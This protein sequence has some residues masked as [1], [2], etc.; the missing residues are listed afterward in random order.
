MKINVTKEAILHAIDL[1]DSDPKLL[2]GRYSS[3]YDLFYKGKTYPPILVLSEANKIVGGG[4]LK[5]SDFKNVQEAFKVLNEFGFD[6][7]SKEGMSL[8]DRLLRFSEVYDEDRKEKFSKSLESFQIICKE[9]PAIMK[10]KLQKSDLPIQ[11]SIGQGNFANYPWVAIF[12]PQVSTGATNGYYVVLLISD[13][14]ERIYLT[15]NQGS[16]LQSKENQLII[17]NH[18]FDVL[19]EVPGFMKGKLPENGLVR[20]YKNDP[21]NKT[22]KKYESTNLFYREYSIKNFNESDFYEHLELLLEAYDECVHR[23]QKKGIMNDEGIEFSTDLLTRDF[24]AAKLNY[25]RK[26][27]Q[28]FVASLLTKPFLLLSGLSGS[29]KTKIAQG[30][31]HW[32]CS[33]TNQYK[34]V[35]VGADWTNREP[36]LG[37]PNGLDPEMYTTPD[38]GVLQ[39]IIEAS[40][41]SHLPYFLIL[42][43]M[44]LSHV[45]RYFADFLS[46]MESNDTI[47]LYTGKERKSADDLFIP[48]ELGWPSNLFI[49]GTVNIDETT[50]MFSPKVLDRANVIEFRLSSKDLNAYLASPSKPN[51]EM[52]VGKGSLM[53]ASFLEMAR[54]ADFLIVEE[55]SNVLSAFF[56]ELSGVGAEFGYRTANEIVTL[57]TKLNKLDPDL[58]S[59]EKIDI[60]VMQKLLPKLHGSRAKIVKVLESML[61]L[62]LVNGKLFRIEDLNARSFED[63]EIRYPISFEKL[64]RM[65]TNVIANGF[66]SYAEA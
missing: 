2:R 8:R 4:E 14:L 58:S 29:G 37:Y 23:S 44:N 51:L 15:L 32:I 3:T 9:I 59:D 64:S 39:L 33:E 40:K 10:R 17:T 62:C 7:R 22:G 5:H 55:I 30:F 21:G 61:K 34:V 12:N 27:T 46:V 19:K 36:L 50:Y 6:V 42:D 52:L 66:T 35:P 16:T 20:R 1:V 43:E 48:F 13:D 47:K 26:F 45:E 63:I 25:S 11:G 18:V 54:S 38:N 60:A 49:I 24:L 41:N 56:V 57:I 65:Y 31:V 53:A 28:R